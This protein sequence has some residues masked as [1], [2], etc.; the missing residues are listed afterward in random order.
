MKAVI[1]IGTEK[2]GTTTL[3]EFLHL[4]RANLKNQGI[5]YLQSPG[6][7]N[8]RKLATYCM[9]HNNVDDHIEDLGIISE[10]KKNT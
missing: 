3:Q 6:E 5:A 1:H 8:N 4:N 7:R 10:S 2:T 9:N